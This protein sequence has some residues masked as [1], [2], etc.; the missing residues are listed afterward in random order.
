[1]LS[2][3]SVGES[4]PNTTGKQSRCSFQDSTGHWSQRSSLNEDLAGAA[5]EC[6][7]WMG[8]GPAG[9][10]EGDICPSCLPV[11]PQPS[12]LVDWGGEC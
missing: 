5:V 10:R 9:E 3:G 2:R 1:M 7:Q 8:E 11:S 6:V 4:D 12:S